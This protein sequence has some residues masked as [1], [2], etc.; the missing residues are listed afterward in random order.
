[1][2]A[3]F[4]LRAMRNAILS[5]AKLLPSLY[6]RVDHQRWLRICEEAEPSAIGEFIYHF[7]DTIC[8][9]PYI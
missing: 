6:E 9:L 7:Y 3:E 4:T 1:M 5:V 8:N 2:E